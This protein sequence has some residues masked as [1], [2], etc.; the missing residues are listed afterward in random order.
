MLAVVMGLSVVAVD[1]TGSGLR[2]RIL[3]LF[4]YSPTSYHSI[5]VPLPHTLDL[6]STC[7]S[8]DFTIFHLQISC[9][10]PRQYCFRQFHIG[11]WGTL[12]KKG[13]ISTLTN[14]VANINVDTRH[15]F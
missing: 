6:A 4:A 15:R 11:L 9:E 5:L 13:Q 10:A 1:K 12:G 7:I 14:M 8:S 2:G 3:S